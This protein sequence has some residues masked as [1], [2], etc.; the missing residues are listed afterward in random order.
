MVSKTSWNSHELRLSRGG[1]NCYV[2]GGFILLHP[3]REVRGMKEVA[4]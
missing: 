4:G 1:E 3:M 2:E